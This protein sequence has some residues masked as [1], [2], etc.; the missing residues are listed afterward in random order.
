[1]KYRL[2][3]NLIHHSSN[4]FLAHLMLSTFFPGLIWVGKGAVKTARMTKEENKL[5]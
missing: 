4:V 1:M 2:D 3:S 5:R